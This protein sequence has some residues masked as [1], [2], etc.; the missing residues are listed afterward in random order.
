LADIYTIRP[1]LTVMAALPLLTVFI[2][3]FFFPAVK[4]GE[5]S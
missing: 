4:S 2:I 3:A 5:R 1:V